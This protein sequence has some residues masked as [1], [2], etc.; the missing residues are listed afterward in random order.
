M[1]DQ[2]EADEFRR[3]LKSTK[4]KLG[5]NTRKL[6]EDFLLRQQL[7]AERRRAGKDSIQEKISFVKMEYFLYALTDAD[8]LLGEIK[9]LRSITLDMQEQ[10]HQAEQRRGTRAERLAQA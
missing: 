5:S 1:L 8:R 3:L 9:K 7:E 10:I 6:A 4:T 2:N